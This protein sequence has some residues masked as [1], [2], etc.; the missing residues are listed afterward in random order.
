M[1]LVIKEFANI[2][3]Y[4]TKETILWNNFCCLCLI[5]MACTIEEDMICG[6]SFLRLLVEFFTLLLL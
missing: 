1:Y 5:V 2:F 6:K 3:H 4:C